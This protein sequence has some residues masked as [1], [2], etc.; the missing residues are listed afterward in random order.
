MSR[1]KS[2]L[3]GQR[4]RCFSARLTEAQHIMFL[5]VGGSRWLREQLDKELAKAQQQ[6]A[7]A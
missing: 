6:K 1:P 5:R 7:P 3:T 4:P 2:P